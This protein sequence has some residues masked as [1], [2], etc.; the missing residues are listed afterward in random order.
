MGIF[1]QA[2][3]RIVTTLESVGGAMGGLAG[4]LIKAPLDLFHGL[5]G[6]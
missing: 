6:G 1:G 4:G 3:G 2:F 5:L